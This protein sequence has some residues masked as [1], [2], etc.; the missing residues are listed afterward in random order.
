MEKIIIACS[1]TN[2]KYEFPKRKWY[3]WNQYDR[4]AMM[5]LHSVLDEVLDAEILLQ[6]YENYAN[7]KLPSDFCRV[8]DG[9]REFAYWIHP[10]YEEE[11]FRGMQVYF[12]QL[13]NTKEQLVV[14]D[15]GEPILPKIM[16][17]LLKDKNFLTVFTLNPKSYEQ[18][19]QQAEAENGLVGMVF[20]EYKE[21]ARYIKQVTKD[22]PALV[23]SGKAIHESNGES[24]LAIV[25]KNSNFLEKIRGNLAYQ[26]PGK[27]FFMDF[28][29]DNDFFYP[30]SKKRMHFTYVSIP[31]FLDNIAKNRYNAVVNE[32]ITFQVINKNVRRRKGNKDGRKE[33]YSDL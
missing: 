6:V 12:S 19:L 13:I 7:A 10:L 16:S 25:G 14:L 1:A 5:R 27:S 26:I 4:I 20:T 8:T 31:I 28:C 11:V 9:Q 22:I 3:Q 15:M 32:G 33:E 17:G 23:I 24:G 29:R 21:F 18:V 2:L 30:L